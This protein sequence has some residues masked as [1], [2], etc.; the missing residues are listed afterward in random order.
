[1]GSKG[2]PERGVRRGAG[3]RN[4]S[5][6]VPSEGPLGPPQGGDGGGAGPS[7]PPGQMLGSVR[8]STPPG[9]KSKPKLALDLCSG[10][11]SVGRRLAQKGYRVISVDIRSMHDPSVFQH[12]CVDL[13]EWDYQRFR[14]G[15]FDLI[16]ASPPC[17]EYSQAKTTAPRKLE[18]ADALVMKVLEIIRYF[19]PRLWWVENP[20]TGMLK[21]RDFMKN[22][23][24]LDIDYCQFSDW[25]YQKPTRFW[26]CPAIASLPPRLCDFL[27]C[28]NLFET[29]GGQ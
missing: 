17:T 26:C 3:T 15:F 4:P 28:P 22:F 29:Q 7:L 12:F 10:T 5:A 25:G 27:S 14:P 13:M 16:A 1:M 24:F 20:R 21:D 18:K 8:Y 6:N 19:R 11:G 9:R 2:P 23:Q